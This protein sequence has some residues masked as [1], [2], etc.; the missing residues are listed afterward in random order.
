[1][2]YLQKT[3][4]RLRWC[5]LIF[6]QNYY[7]KLEPTLNKV[8]N[9]Q[10]AE[11]VVILYLCVRIRVRG[12][13]TRL[14]TGFV[15]HPEQNPIPSFQ[16]FCGL[17]LHPL[18]LGGNGK[19]GVGFFFATSSLYKFHFVLRSIESIALHLH[20]PC[21]DPRRYAEIERVVMPEYASHHHTSH[22]PLTFVRAPASVWWCFAWWFR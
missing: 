15:P 5:F 13:A 22:R 20:R 19:D 16:L 6:V 1:M 2:A 8:T 7:T 21:G 4:T 10:R 17:P 12:G 14:G 9:L 3:P 18:P 11:R